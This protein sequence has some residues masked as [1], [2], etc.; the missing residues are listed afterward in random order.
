[1]A[2]WRLTYLAGIFLGFWFGLGVSEMVLWRRFDRERRLAHAKRQS[3]VSRRV[4][5]ERWCA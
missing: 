4:A 1:M 5:S 3:E 2:I